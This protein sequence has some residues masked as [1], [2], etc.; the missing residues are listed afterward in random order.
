MLAVVRTI[1]TAPRHTPGK[2]DRMGSAM[3]TFRLV[4][5]TGAD[6]EH[7]LLLRVGRPSYPNADRT[8]EDAADDFPAVVMDALTAWWTRWVLPARCR[9]DGH[10]PGPH[11]VGVVADHVEVGFESEDLREDDGMRT[12]DVWLARHGDGR[13]TV[14][15]TD[16]HAEALHPPDG[17]IGPAVPLSVL[18]LAEGSGDGDLRD[19]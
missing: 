19:A 6:C 4:R 13:G 5:A 10:E 15:S 16:P 8:A 2:D 3:R 18:L 17:T 12:F 9:W 7:H 1:V 11:Q 14:L